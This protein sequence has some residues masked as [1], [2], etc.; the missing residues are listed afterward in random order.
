[1]TDQQ[2][3]AAAAPTTPEQNLFP[4]VEECETP[5][6][7]RYSLRVF[8]PKIKS[9]ILQG[10]YLTKED[11]TRDLK[12]FAI[13]LPGDAVRLTGSYT[14]CKTGGIAIINGLIGKVEGRYLITFYANA[15]RD[16]VT[17]DCGG[18]PGVFVPRGNFRF[19]G[20]KYNGFF[21]KWKDRPRASGG[22]R[23]RQMVNLWE[24]DGEKD[25][26]LVANIFSGGFH[27]R[28]QIQTEDLEE[29]ITRCGWTVTNQLEGVTDEARQ[30]ISRLESLPYVSSRFENNDAQGALL[31]WNKRLFSKERALTPDM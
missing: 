7:S 27:H 29:L 1:L 6:G 18:G 10:E 3:A 28:L 21:W 13:P 16:S 9:G 24:W 2:S 14:G 30:E 15:F 8:S 5:R 17:V 25:L 12:E 11:A 31:W 26:G 19:T 4:F 20:E 22:E 23:Y